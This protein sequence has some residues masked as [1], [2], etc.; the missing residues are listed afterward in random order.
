MPIYP[1]KNVKKDGMQKYRVVVS[2]TDR[3]GSYKKVERTAYGKS[4]A[5]VKE[6]ELRIRYSQTDAQPSHSIT[7]RSLFD[8]YI[9]SKSYEVRES[10]LDKSKRILSGHVLDTMGDKKIDKLFPNVLQEW[11]HHIEEIDSIKTLSTKKGIYKEFHALLNYAVK[12]DYLTVNP[13]DKV[14]NFKS[15]YEG[16]KEMLFYTPEEFSRYITAARQYCIEQEKKGYFGAWNYYVFFMTAFFTGMR[17]GEINALTW[18]DIEGNTIHI[19]KSVNQKLRGND[20]ITPPKN[21]SSIRD[22][23]MPLQLR[24]AIDEHKARYKLLPSF[25]KKMFICGGDAPVRDTTVALMNDMFAKRAEVKSIRIHDFRHSHA[26]L[27]AHKG[28]S[29]HEIARRLGHSDI[30]MTLQT[31]SHL[32]PSET[33]RALNVLEEVKI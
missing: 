8:E 5:K 28:I 1:V 16:K 6:E 33:E 21:K 3:S 15:A 18:E 4:N 30:K 20:R 7:V 12:M 25:N 24:T 19:T 11:K 17:K 13:L 26:S 10:T 27:L 29:I 32:Y 9:R 2:Y 31:Y 22:I 14:G 23:Q